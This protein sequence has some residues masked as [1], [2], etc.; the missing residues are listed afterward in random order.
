MIK[1][2]KYC[3]SI[4]HTHENKF[5]F[6][7]A[8]ETQT[9]EEWMEKIDNGVATWDDVAEAIKSKGMGRTVDAVGSLV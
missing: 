6:W 7:T 1:K 4:N 8:E 9:L 5:A 3:K 2:Q